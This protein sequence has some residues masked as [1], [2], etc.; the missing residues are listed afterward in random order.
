MRIA[1]NTVSDQIVRQIQNLGVSQ[2][3]LQTQVGT[4]Q[5]IAQ[6][7]DDP[8]AAGRVLNRQSDRRRVDQYILNAS[9]ALQLSQASYSGISGLKDISDRVTEIG[10][11]GQSAQDPDALKAYGSELNQLI[12][13]AV[14][15]GNSKFGNDYIYAGTAVDTPPY[16]VARDAAGNVTSVT[17]AGNGS[18]AQIA[19]SETA[20]VSPGTSGATNTGIRDFINQIVALRDALNNN[21]SAGI[22]SAQTSLISSED[23]LVSAISE[24]GAVQMRIDVNKAQQETLGTNLD[25]V[26]SSDTSTDMAST[27][28]KLTQAQTSYQAA[29]QSSASIMRLSLLDY[30]K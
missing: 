14:Q 17:Y 10:T 15:I 1:S 23:V 30:L 29:L 2:A 6:L 26:I 28:V 16:T 27:I 7:E 22:T 19:L 5:R 24:T 25:S 20:S 12:E 21:N 11:L 4:G 3:K 18:Q 9:R 8:A 13:Q